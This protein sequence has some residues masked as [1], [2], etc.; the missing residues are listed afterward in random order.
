MSE[1]SES[2]PHIPMPGLLTD[3]APAFSNRD[4]ETSGDAGP[5]YDRPEGDAVNASGHDPVAEYAR[6]LWRTLS[7][8]VKYLR[9][10]IARATSEPDT[11]GPTPLLGTD[12]QWGAWAAV[13]ARA[14][15]VLA[16]PAGDEGYG[17]QEARLEYQNNY[18]FRTDTDH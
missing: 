8:A 1:S 10:D 7:E 5:I 11:A 18:L 2:W 4:P 17:E 6:Q 13:Y 16:G 9:D 3:A 12:D 14:L 15:S